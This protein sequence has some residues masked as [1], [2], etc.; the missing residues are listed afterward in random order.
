M[1]F[2]IFHESFSNVIYDEK[3]HKYFVN[4]K[5]LISA[6]TLIDKYCQPFDIDR[7]AETTAKKRNVS[8][9]SLIEEWNNKS[10][11]S[12]NRGTHFH[13]F[14]ESFLK[15]NQ[16]DIE[17]ETNHLKIKNQF[18]NFYNDFI[19]DKT[20]IYFEKVLYLEE[21]GIAGTIDCLMFDEKDKIL[22]FIDWKTNDEISMVNKYQNMNFPLN[23]LD[24]S[25]FNIYSL[26]ISLYR[27]MIENVILN[28][29]LE[30]ENL[31][32]KSKNILVQ[33]SELKETYSVYDLPYL[34]Y[35]VVQ[36]L[37]HYNKNKG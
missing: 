14:I 23:R 27:Y 26:Q 37:N 17:N 33:F 9:E 35:S 28:N 29:S 7:I 6:T 12:K 8:K 3:N 4:N 5:N 15:N 34:K 10:E 16:V 1:K 19:K 11:K 18:L 20:L 30:W 22:Y 25:S 31:K 13:K 24:Q 32:D 2:D 21:Q 36:L